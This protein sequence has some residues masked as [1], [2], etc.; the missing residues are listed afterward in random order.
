M[1]QLVDSPTTFNIQPMQI[2]TKNRFYNGTDFKPSILPKS[3]TAPVDATY[4]GLLECPCTTR[5]NKEIN[6]TYSIQ[7]NETCDKRIDSSSECFR[8][9]HEVYPN[10]AHETQMIVDSP[11][12]P[13]GCSI[14]QND[15]LVGVNLDLTQKFTYLTITT[16]LLGYIKI[17]NLW[18]CIKKQMGI[19]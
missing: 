10:L 12:Y 7:N 18:G 3:S 5:I 14:V 13:I 4:S 6:V 19:K 15:F 17:F 2:D 16:F 9:A 11:K 8:A 1:V